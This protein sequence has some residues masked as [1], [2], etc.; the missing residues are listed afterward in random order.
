MRPD[1]PFLPGPRAVAVM[2][3]EADLDPEVGQLGHQELRVWQPCGD[4]ETAGLQRHLHD[5]GEIP[6]WHVP[7]VAITGHLVAAGDLDR[8]Q[9]SREAGSRLNRHPRPA[10]RRLAHHRAEEVHDWPADAGHVE[11]E[12][13]I[14][15]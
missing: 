1:A 14:T 3:A 5:A 15:A 12:R 6:L 11:R 4:L 13:Q 8:Y 2:P 9:A 10:D 7:D